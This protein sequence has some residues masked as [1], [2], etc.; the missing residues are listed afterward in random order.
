MELSAASLSVVVYYGDGR[1]S[2]R[3]FNDISHLSG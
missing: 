3:L 2:L 1:S